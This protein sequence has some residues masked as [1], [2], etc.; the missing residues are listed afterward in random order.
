MAAT[1]AARFLAIC[2]SGLLLS[3]GVDASEISDPENAPVLSGAELNWTMSC[4]G[5]HGTNAEG[6]DGGAP[7]MAGQVSR[8]LKVEGGRQYLVRVPGVAFAN[9][10]DAEVAELLNWM[11]RKFDKENI[12]DSFSPYDEKEVGRLR[13]KPLITSVAE[14]RRKLILKMQ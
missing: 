8:F 5:C 1:L 12:P 4:R 7:N 14:V 11:L 2:V 3:V 13:E 9:L 6:T 10:S